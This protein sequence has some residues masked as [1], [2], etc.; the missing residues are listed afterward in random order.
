MKRFFSFTLVCCM[1]LTMVA[2]SS[3]NVHAASWHDGWSLSGGAIRN[4][5][6][7]VISPTPG[8]TALAQTKWIP[9]GSQYDIEWIM[10]V[11]TSVGNAAF[12]VS[13]GS[14]RAYLTIMEKGISYHASD[15]DTKGTIKTVSHDIYDETHT[16]RLIGDGGNAEL[17]IDGYYLGVLD[18]RPWTEEPWIKANA[19]T[20]G[21]KAVLENVIIR[22]VA[23]TVV[24]DKTEKQPA[25]EAFRFDFEDG[26]DHSEWQLGTKWKI[27]NG[28]LISENNTD[29]QWQ[30]ILPIVYDGDFVFKTR[31]RAAKKGFLN[32]VTLFWPGCAAQI[33][34]KPD[35]LDLANDIGR[36]V[37]ETVDIG[38][39]W[40]EFTIETTDNMQRY[41]VYLDGIKY[42]DTEVDLSSHTM[43]QIRF[44]TWGYVADPVEF[45]VDWISYEP[46]I[47]RDRISIQSPMEDAEY[48]EGEKIQFSA[49]VDSE[50]MYD[51]IT[52]KVNGKK[53][54]TGYAP[55]Y[56]VVIDGL[57]P[58]NYLV[59]AECG[60]L[61]S[62]KVGFRVIPA[63][64]GTITTEET[65][66]K[67]KVKSEFY[68]E[69]NSI[70]LVEYLVDGILF[71]TANNK[72]FQSVLQNITPGRHQITAIAYNEK[73]MRI[74]ELSDSVVT[75]LQD[76]KPSMSFANEIRYTTK[77]D[78]GNAV[79]ELKNGNHHLLLTHTPEKVV[80][81]TD[82]GEE[83]FD[84]GTGEFTIFT[85][86]PTADVYRNG[87][88]AF[89]FYLP[90]TTENAVSIK[91][92]GLHLEN[93]AITV[94]E[95]RK[96]Y[97]IKRD[98]KEKEAIYHIPGLSY[99]YNLDFVADREDEIHLAVNDGYFRMDLT[100]EDEKIFVWTTKDDNTDPYKTYLADVPEG[101]K[102]IYFR[103]ETVGGMSRLYGNGRWLASF[104]CVHSVAGKAL[105]VEN[106]KGDGITYLGIHDNNDLYIYE[107]DFTNKGEFSSENYWYTKNDMTNLVD[108]DSGMMI[109]DALNKNN[110]GVELFAFSGQGS[111]S[112]DVEIKKAEGGVWFVYARGGLIDYYTKIGYNYVTEQYEVVRVDRETE[113]VVETSSGILPMKKSVRIELKVCEL[114]T[115][116]KTATLYVDGIPVITDDA[117]CYMRGRMGIFA[118]NAF[119]YLKN[120]KYRGDAKPL[121]GVVEFHSD[122][123]A[124]TSQ[125]F[126][127]LIE[128]TDRLT[129]VG[130]GKRY[131]STD[132]GQIW[133]SVPAKDADSYDNVKLSSGKILQAKYL[134]TGTDEDGRDVKTVAFYHSM[135]NGE[136][137]EMIS[138]LPFEKA[139]FQ[140]KQNSM[141]QG[142]SGRIYFLVMES[143]D[144]DYGT[145]RIFYSDDE[146]KTWTESIF[147]DGK[148]MNMTLGEAT[149]IEY[150]NGK[151]HCYFRSNTGFISYFESLDRGETWD[152]TKVYSTPFFSPASMYN[153]DYDPVEKGMV[154]IGWTYDNA[155]L[156]ARVQFNRHRWAMAKTSD[157]KEWEFVGTYHENNNGWNNFMNLNV[158]AAN[159]VVILEAPVYVDMS[160]SEYTALKVTQDKAFEKPVKKFER[161]HM[162][163]LIQIAQTE[164]VR[165][166]YWERTLVAHPE[167][168][169]ILHNGE[170]IQN[171]ALGEY[172]SLEYASALI[173]AKIEE[174]SEQGITLQLGS[175]EEC[176]SNGSLL[177]ENGKWYVK[178]KEFAEAFDLVLTEKD[179]VWILSQ[180]TDWSPGQIRAFRFSLDLYDAE[181]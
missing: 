96:S 56:K 93:Y 46:K 27:E 160:Y 78:E 137:Y 114:N 124:G 83:S 131:E 19:G 107:D 121:A 71:E 89:S 161:L 61:S 25:T 33:D 117:A 31:V 146:G 65:D 23:Q 36:K 91:E 79:Y 164:V 17:Y 53:V 9:Q 120:A 110:A 144:E 2:I 134:V 68:D 113:T 51:E 97:F 157:G 20:S 104:R 143:N 123:G 162:K 1:M 109:L 147:I 177:H 15:F 86:G 95:E 84:G 72:P 67:L 170:L 75:G 16:Y 38:T 127:D 49:M 50:K 5:N 13:T 128:G 169:N 168:G 18:L 47:S 140:H 159:D 24:K 106:M 158:Q 92:D 7:V 115:D 173:G 119:V 60:E 102:K 70:E 111:L 39:E 141:K 74:A 66:G 171:A 28:Y 122:A 172:I 26:E 90:Q 103:V 41:M 139:D 149:I 54:A 99:I 105:A 76:G 178:S 29:T 151:T 40:H 118:D 136:S 142:P 148:E 43:S 179:G 98:N 129:L 48:L 88:L 59:S 11:N 156:D 52:Y 116:T 3:S 152:L 55:D 4:G 150:E 112:A 101:E 37:S 32:S 8:K 82:T 63:I 10:T 57:F 175:E 81:L 154:Y 12:V 77:G 14:Y 100:I 135:D 94:P 166:K 34:I 73:G 22:S 45:Y 108:D 174:K 180:Y 165:P 42:V 44:N 155:A 87:Q 30:A 167:S 130:Y 58:A 69:F 64:S 35:K 145:S 138:H 163:D 153:V 126:F 62:E 21:V 181:S 125:C 6:E 80:Y 133:K 176:F 85:E 132:K